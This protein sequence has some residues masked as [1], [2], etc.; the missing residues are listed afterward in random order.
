[1]EKGNIVLWLASG[2]VWEE[3][4]PTSS[5]VFT[6]T[7]FCFAHYIAHIFLDLVNVSLILSSHGPRT[8]V[9]TL[10]VCVCVCV[11]VILVGPQLMTLLPC[12]P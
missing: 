4:D 11:C 12:P 7:P 6:S 1:M 2:S 3:E 5:S 9:F 10:C 8:R